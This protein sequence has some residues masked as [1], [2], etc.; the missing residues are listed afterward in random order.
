M[1]NFFFAELISKVLPRDF[2][3]SERP[4]LCWHWLMYPISPYQQNIKVNGKNKWFFPNFSQN[5]LAGA[6]RWSGWP[7]CGSYRLFEKFFAKVTQIANFCKIPH[8]HAISFHLSYQ[9]HLYGLCH[10]LC[11]KRVLIVLTHIVKWGVPFM[12]S[13][14]LT[15]RCSC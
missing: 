5:Y 10:F 7:C 9:P 15:Y 4:C 1:N 13:G 2:W 3:R 14:H 12:K 8:Q 6:S 11:D